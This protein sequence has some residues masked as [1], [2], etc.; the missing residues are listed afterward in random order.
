MDRGDE[1]D[2]EVRE[3]GKEFMEKERALTGK[4][5]LSCL[6]SQE[7]SAFSCLLF[8]PIRFP[9]V[10]LTVVYE[11]NL[12]LIDG[13]WEGEDYFNSCR[14]PLTGNTLGYYTQTQPMVIS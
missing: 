5:F 4:S 9:C 7:T 2:R 10:V 3:Q 12:R 6:A 8:H 13:S 11:E 14:R 1:Q